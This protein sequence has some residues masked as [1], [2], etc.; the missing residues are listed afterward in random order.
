MNTEL[1]NNLLDK[2]LPYVLA[3]FALVVFVKSFI[4]SSLWTDEALTW[5]VSNAGFTEVISRS[6][7]FQGQ[8]PLYYL[9]VWLVQQ[10]GFSSEFALRF[11]SIIFILFS[12]FFLFKIAK[13]LFDKRTAW[14]SLL[15]FLSFNPVLVSLSARPYAMALAFTLASTYFFTVWIDRESKFYAFLSMICLALA[16]YAHYL[17]ILAGAVLD[18][19]LFFHGSI[20]RQIKFLLIPTALLVLLCLPGLSHIRHLWEVKESL[21]FLKFPGIENVFKAIFPPIGLIALICG[22]IAALIAV[23][24]PLPEKIKEHRKSLYIVL[25]WAAVGPIFFYAISLALGNSLF[26]S[27]YFLWSLPGAAIFFAYFLANSRSNKTIYWI[28]CVA[29]ILL[30]ARSIDRSWQIE[31]WKSAAGHVSE[32]KAS[33]IFLYSGLIESEQIKKEIGGRVG[34][35]LNA[36]F[37]YYEVVNVIA[38]GPNFD[39]DSINIFDDAI[40]V[41]NKKYKKEEQESVG[42][43]LAKKIFKKSSKKEFALVE[44]F[45]N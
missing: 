12:C 4:F 32:K 33:Q 11:P 9:V 42:E 26:T 29:F 24:N 27:R 40:L 10:L 8:S 43:K 16:F 37:R 15:F 1:K 2:L 41:A 38:V 20:R 19:I 31:D 39:F 35:Y 28:F 14:I 17:F 22:L 6:S 5:W 30:F 23:G 36:P 7:N 34:E 44:V 21:Y 45:E 25:I 3:V 13:Y 18:I